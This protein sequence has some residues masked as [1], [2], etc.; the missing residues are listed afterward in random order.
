MVKTSKRESDDISPKQEAV[1]KSVR[2]HY[3]IERELADKL[4]NSK[5]DDRQKL[6]SEVYDEF[7]RRVPNHPQLV[8]KM[9]ADETRRAIAK[10]M[11]V[12]GRFLDRESIYLEVGPGDCALAMHVASRTNKVYAIDVSAEISKTK[13]TPENFELIVSD[14]TS[15]PVDEESV[16]IAYS[17]QLMEHLHPDDATKQLKNI[18]HALKPGGKYICATPNRLSG[19]HDVSYYFDDVAT[20]F[21]LKEYTIGELRALMRS[22][23]FRKFRYYAAGRLRLPVRLVESIEWL[24]E[25]LPG[26]LSKKVGRFRPMRILLGLTLVGVK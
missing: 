14:G 20:G 18:Y 15:I 6:Y 12:L 5:P 2:E 19:P 17:N 7:Y 24:V 11:R 9:S 1:D 3:E 25:H 13:K 22:V 8:Q 23:G 10:Q 16:D 21:H 26:R 4:R